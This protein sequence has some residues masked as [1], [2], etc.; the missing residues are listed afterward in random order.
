M[1]NIPRNTYSRFIAKDGHAIYHVFSIKANRMK[2]Y[3]N[4]FFIPWELH[5]TQS[6]FGICTKLQTYESKSTEMAVKPI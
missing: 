4:P 1:L 6:K 3:F 5:I 2:E